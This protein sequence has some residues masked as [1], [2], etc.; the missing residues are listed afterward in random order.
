MTTRRHSKSDPESGMILV[1]VLWLVAMMTVLV[2]ALNAYARSSLS[3]AGIEADR[4]RNQLVLES[5]IDAAVGTIL[6]TPAQRRL[7][8]AGT[9]ASIDLGGGAKVEISITDASAFID[10]NRAE[11]DLIVTLPQHLDVPAGGG[12]AIADAITKWRDTVNPPDPASTE[13]QKGSQQQGQQR[14]TQ[15]NAA[16]GGAQQAD[17][18]QP[19]PDGAPVTSHPGAFFS[20]A[21]LYAIPGVAAADVDKFLPFVGLYS[22][23]GK[24][25]PMAAPQTVL[26][27]VPGLTPQQAAAIVAARAI[28]RADDPAVQQIVGALPKFLALNE[29][30]S[31]VVTVKGLSGPGVLPGSLLKV[32]VVLEASGTPIYR[33]MN[34]SW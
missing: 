18:Q 14:Q 20:L 13:A 34:W 32:V 5:G 15:G 3:Q 19:A 9:P 2:V 21:Q 24:V 10:I 16:G 12:S 31:Y 17:Q 27:S 33:V 22:K 11:K 25:N 6:A 1:L 8:F 28:G 4:L 29:P 7:L 23:D 26:Q 30:K